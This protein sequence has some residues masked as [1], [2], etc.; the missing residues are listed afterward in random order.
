MQ[1]AKGANQ[2]ALQEDVASIL[3]ES[4]VNLNLHTSP[5]ALTF[6]L[7]EPEHPC[8]FIRTQDI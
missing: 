7:L 8:W 5:L 3:Q 6:P 2:V 4:Y 1:K